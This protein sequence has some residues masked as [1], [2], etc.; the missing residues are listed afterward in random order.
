MI[1]SR[2]MAH[3]RAV[4]ERTLSW[5]EVQSWVRQVFFSGEALES[6]QTNAERLSP[7]AAAH[8]IL[9]N[10]FGLIPFGP[11]RKDGEERVAVED[12]DL[13]LVLKVRP[14][15]YMSPFM[16]RKITMS[17]AFWHGFGAVW[18]RKGPD[19]QVVQRLPLPSDCCS[20]RKDLETGQYWYDYSVDGV[21]KTF[22]NYE[23]SFLYFETY[24]GIRGRGVLDLARET[25]ALDAMAQRYGKKFYQNGARM[26]GIV[27]VETDMDREAR[28]K[29][30]QEF[31]TYASDD[32]FA[33]AVLDHGMDFTP[34]GVS[35]SDAQFIETRNFS[36]EEI[37]R[38]T[39]IP[40]HMLQTGKESYNSNSQQ[41]LNYVTDTL[42]P[43]VVQWESEDSYKLP[44]PQDRR[45]GV[46]IRGNVEVLLR[47]DPTTR[48]SF[49]EKMIQ[50]AIY[51]PDECRAKEEKNPIPGGLGKQFVM[52]KNLGSLESV[53]KGDA[54]D[55]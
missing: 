53:L 37:S 26:S 24:D 21:Q 43:Y 17:N 25:I 33:V 48:A 55:G 13:N 28:Q 18:N 11:Y 7:V 3:P 2:S 51:N 30:K 4:E 16:M 20:I 47:A 46:Y 32:A 31:R 10:S 45:A 27:K 39:G 5:D 34:M 36:V 42:L 40:K 38:F 8:R 1:L 29:V 15:D 52:T 44:T 50:H 35:Q 19:G 14:N 41:R 23:L 9:T 12:P 54:A 6:S 22:S 49:Y